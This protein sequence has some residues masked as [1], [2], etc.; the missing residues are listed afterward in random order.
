MTFEQKPIEKMHID[1][2]RT[3]VRHMRAVHAQF[4]EQDTDLEIE[5]ADLHAE[6]KHLRDLLLALQAGLGTL[7]A[8]ANRAYVEPWRTCGRDITRHV[9]FM[10][11]QGIA[12]YAKKK[13]AKADKS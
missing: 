8:T 11:A 12:P 3:E 7:T 6:N 1:E 10:L 5:R 13:K 2:L 9:N 4:I